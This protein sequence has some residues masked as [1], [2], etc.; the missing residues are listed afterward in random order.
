MGEV[1]KGL[2]NV[3][4]GKYKDNNSA[5]MLCPPTIRPPVHFFFRLGIPIDPQRAV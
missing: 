1:K 4:E 5:L 3:K 2:Y